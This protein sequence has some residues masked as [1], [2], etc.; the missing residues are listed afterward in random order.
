M[1]TSYTTIEGVSPSDLDQR[2]NSAFK[3]GYDFYGNPYTYTLH[4]G[5]IKHCQAM[6]KEKKDE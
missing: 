4:N 3:R 5:R 6:V 1:A 2:V